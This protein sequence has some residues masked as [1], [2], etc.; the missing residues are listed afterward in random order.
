MTFAIGS[1]GAFALS[2]INQSRQND[3]IAILAAQLVEMQVTRAETTELMPVTP[4]AA[5]TPV[6]LETA[7]S[8]SIPSASAVLAARAPTAVAD[9]RTQ[10]EKIADAIAAANRNK[11]R[12][13]IEGVVAGLYSITAESNDGTGSRIALNS[14]NAS[15][16]AQ[17]LETLLAQAAELNFCWLGGGGYT[18]TGRMSLPDAAM[19]KTI[20]TE[21]DITGFKIS[22]YHKGRLLGSWNAADRGPNTTWHLRFDPAGMIFLTGG[23]FAG[24]VSQGWNANGNVTDCGAPGFGF[25]SS[26][27]AQ[28]ICLNGAYVEASSIAPDTPLLATLAPVTPECRNTAAVSRAKR[29]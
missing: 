13:L 5:A 10:D 11:M 2:Q 14:V 28:D 20:L 12:M 6:A 3:A 18:M 27:F 29:P 21:D 8:T 7:P 16:T 23:S 15:S 22:G 1:V 24:F 25:N 17:E 19:F 9:E 4:P 26:N